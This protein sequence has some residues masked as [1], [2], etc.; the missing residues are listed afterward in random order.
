MEFLVYLEVIEMG[1]ILTQVGQ[2]YGRLTIIEK[3]GTYRSKNDLSDRFLWK[4]QCECGNITIVRSHHIRDPKR[5]TISC[6]CYRKGLPKKKK[7]IAALHG[8]ITQYKLQAKRR[9][10]AFKLTK[11]D[12]IEFFKGN[13]YYCGI[14]PRQVHKVARDRY[15]Y[16]GIDRKDNKIDYLKENCVTCCGICNRAKLSLT[17]EQFFEWL[18]RIVEKRIESGSKSSNN[19]P[20][21]LLPR[22]RK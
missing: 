11:K 16:N 1:R 19:D 4:C 9:K 6:G 5:G 18:D 15:I 21:S 3:Y 22:A 12:L 2:K 10:R 20:M 8:L 17:E 7:L 13:C 14:E